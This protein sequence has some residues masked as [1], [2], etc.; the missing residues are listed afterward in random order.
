MKLLGSEVARSR[1]NKSWLEKIAYQFPPRLAS[2][3]AIPASCLAR[4]REGSYFVIVSKF[5]NTD[6]C[7]HLV[8]FFNIHSTD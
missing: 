4:M 8:F 2:S 6:V 1:Q 7:V 5:Q 3:S